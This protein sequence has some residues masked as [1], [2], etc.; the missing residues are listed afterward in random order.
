EKQSDDVFGVRGGSPTALGI[1]ACLI[2]NSGE[3]DNLLASEN[4][5]AKTAMLSCARLIRAVLPVGKVAENL[6]SPNKML[7]AAAESYL[8]SQDSP[9]ARRIVLSLHPNE[10]KILGARTYFAGNNSSGGSEYLP[11][12]F[13]SVNESMPSAAY[14]IYNGYSED[15]ITTEKKLQK[16]VKENQELLGIYAYDDNFVRM[17][18]DKA[19]FSWQEDKA[20]YRER[21]LTREEFDSLKSYLAAEKVDEL[22]PFLSDCEGDC[23]GKELLMLGRQGGRRVFSLS[24]LPLPKFFAGLEQTFADL[25]QPPAKLH[26]WLEKNISGLEILFENDN[27]QA[28]AVWKVGDDFRVLINNEAR[29]KQIDTEI[30]A[31]NEADEEVV[32]PD[33][34]KIEQTRQK[35]REQREYENYSW[36]KFSGGKLA[37]ITEQPGGFEYL[38]KA[39]GA[40]IRAESR[41]WKAR[42]A[43]FEIR[44]SGE[45]LYKI[46]RGGQTTKIRDGYFD[47]PLVTA[48]GRWLV[49]TSYGE[50]G[51][52]L[53]RINLATNKQFAVKFEEYPLVETVAFIP[54]LN[55]VLLFGGGYSEYESEEEDI[56]QR[57][58]E[59]FLLDA[60]TGAIQ[61]AKGELRPL[62]QQSYR[63][64]QPNGI[65]DEFWAAVPD[66]AKDETQVGI[67]NAK[68]FTFKP[69][70]KISQI[71]FNSMQMWA[72]AGKIYFVYE[73]H[74]LALPLPK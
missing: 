29:R 46:A 34:E 51:R 55:K 60:E 14:Y 62:A 47:K 52:Q 45:G 44:S 7:A 8:E 72:D 42:T 71:T 30:E 20:R 18:R 32:E 9:E 6:K 31:Q 37:G 67:Y 54:Q 61:K 39:D 56:S 64:L 25:R 10:A 53:V 23:E 27:L 66:S 38:P 65:A 24:A 41:Q 33:Y 70:V 11:A 58:G 21:E 59:Y 26:Y 16:E 22:P 35:R 12:L 5:E 4:I 63:P 43:T 15:L 3:Y 28:V 50:E 48:N 57:E 73:G 36:N 13:A 68:T 40:A 2:E 49:A 19:V 74:L 17:Y 69:L 1:A